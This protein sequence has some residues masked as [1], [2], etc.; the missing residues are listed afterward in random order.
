MGVLK[1]ALELAEEIRRPLLVTDSRSQPGRECKADSGAGD[2]QGSGVPSI[3]LG[4][5]VP[6]LRYE[7]PSA[8]AHVGPGDWSCYACKQ[9]RWWISIHGARVCGVCHPPASEFLVREW[10][11]D[12]P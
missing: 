11:G 6:G 12:G 9:S 8:R 5:Y 1:R 3:R 4:S 7:S 10:A 2:R